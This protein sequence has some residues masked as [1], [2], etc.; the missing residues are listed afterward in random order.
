MCMICALNTPS[1]QLAA[2]DQHLDS[3]GISGQRNAMMSLGSINPL[4]ENTDAAETTGTS[5][6]ME[7]GQSFFGTIDSA[8]DEDW[9]AI[10]LVQGTVYD[11]RL[12]G[13]GVTFNSDPLLRI[14]DVNGVEV[15]SNDDGFTSGSSTH[16]TDSALTFTAAYTGTYYMEADS[17]S[18]QTGG[19]ILSATED[20]AAV[21]GPFDTVLTIDEMAW[22]LINNGNAYFSAPEA[23]AFNVGGDN[24]L[25]VNITGLTAEGQ[26][27]ARQALLAWTAVT[28]IA[29]TEVS[30]GGEIAFDDV[31]TGAFAQPAYSGST[32]TSAA[33]N[34]GTD[35]LSNFGT[36][37]DSYSFETYIHEIGHALGL[38]HGGNYN[39][40]AT[41]G[42]DN[43]YAND[44]LAWSI[45]SYMQAENDEFASGGDFNTFVGASFRYI[46]TPQIVDILAIQ[47]LYGVVG[48][49]IFGGNTTYGVG[50]NTGLAAIDGAI[51]S[52]ALLAMT[53]FD[54]GGI[55]TLNFSTA[56]VAQDIDLRDG[57]LSSVMGGVLN[58]GIARGVVIENVISGSGNDKITGNA[59]ANTLNGGTGTDTLIGGAGHDT[60]VTNGGDTITELANQGTDQVNSSITYTLG[61]NLENLVLTGGST[62]N[63]TGN[64]LAN[65]IT[66]NTANN[67][68]NG[69]SGV[70]TLIGGAGDD[71]YFTDG[72]DTITEAVNAGSDTVKSSVTYTLGAN[73]EHLVLTGATAINGTGNAV[74]NRITGNAAAN[75]LSGGAGADTL[76]GGAGRDL[77]YGGAADGAT[78]VFVF[79]AAS[80]SG[81]GSAA[82][83]II[84]NFVSG[85]DDISLTAIDANMALVGNQAFAWAGITAQAHAV[86]FVVSGTNVLI[87][88]DTSGDVI[89]D[90]E[91]L[92]TGI[93]SVAAGDLLL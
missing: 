86:W 33:V 35:W 15:G 88:G 48:A 63:G 10:Q 60:Y 20:P 12:L 38:G 27:L 4:S 44:S 22:Q 24:A 92:I 19:Y 87:R 82:R 93:T 41:Y 56:T 26:Y 70:D 59:A 1:D 75:S 30:S 7:V 16:E 47:H 55:D 32:I 79:N 83:D 80:E 5:Y 23:A 36:T 77:L 50:G 71:S 62:I 34:I 31:Q 72:G 42:T 68:L 2:L 84:S 45:M 46:F 61:A 76:I 18:T 14:R 89:F 52:G 40:S 69:G 49:P 3:G 21:S 51:N 57:T 78:D 29:F 58:L 81:N 67:T 65:R 6:T 73:L 74:A 91:I 90:F 9:V 39:G 53:V 54:E 66:G 28:G 17:F 8:T 85:I 64:A 37:L 43:F 25:T 11:F 13:F